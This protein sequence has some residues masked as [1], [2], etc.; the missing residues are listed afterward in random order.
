MTKKGSKVLT[1][2]SLLSST[3]A[4]ATLKLSFG[5]MDDYES[6]GSPRWASLKYCICLILTKQPLKTV[7]LQ[8]LPCIKVSTLVSIVN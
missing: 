3:C 4:K 7:D 6:H 8:L 5:T 1:V 2:H